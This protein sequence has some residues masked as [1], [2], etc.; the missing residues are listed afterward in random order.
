M[1]QFRDS[2]STDIQR[3][4]SSIS[5]KL[6][7]ANNVAILGAGATGLVL[8]GEIRD[9]NPDVNVEVIG[10]TVLSNPSGLPNYVRDDVK[11]QLKD[12]NIKHIPHY[13]KGNFRRGSWDERIVFDTEVE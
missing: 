10:K 7:E 13:A 4:I 1:N 6:T 9:S 5:L 2:Q 11:R 3:S 8:A 12:Y